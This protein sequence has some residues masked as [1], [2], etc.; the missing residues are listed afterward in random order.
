MTIYSRFTHSQQGDFLQLCKCLPEGTFINSVYIQR[1]NICHKQMVQP[2]MGWGYDDVNGCSMLQLFSPTKYQPIET[3]VQYWI[4][5]LLGPMRRNLETG[6]G[7]MPTVRILCGETMPVRP[8]A[9]QAMPTRQRLSKIVRILHD[10]NGICC[11]QKGLH[12]PGHGR[13]I[14]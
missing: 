8:H 4:Y 9:Y 13:R 10:P 6:V 2:M 12:L 5:S 1:Y 3:L 7:I 14:G 11:M